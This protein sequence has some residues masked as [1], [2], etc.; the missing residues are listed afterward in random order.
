M[1]TPKAAWGAKSNF[2]LF[3][4]ASNAG[5]LKVLIENFENILERKS[6]KRFQNR[7]W[8]LI[9]MLRHNADI[10]QN[11]D[12]P[13][14]ENTLVELEHIKNALEK[15]LKLFSF[16]EG[17]NSITS[18]LYTYQLISRNLTD[19]R[20]PIAGI[21]VFS[22]QL[23]EITN[24]IKENL[25]KTS[26]NTNEKKGAN[27]SLRNKMR[28]I[29]AEELARLFDLELEMKPTKYRGGK[30]EKCF[31][32]LLE[33]VKF[34]I[35]NRKLSYSIPADLLT[36][37]SEAIDN[38]PNKNSILLSEGEIYAGVTGDFST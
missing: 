8:Q 33:S 5:E 1:P 6:T 30:F 31:R 29:S 15:N 16:N 36:I 22:Q 19:E 26:E 14:M 38:Y 7:V 32:L 12:F 10:Y 35:E 3:P 21:F 2:N 28:D 34:N 23:L 37:I 4:Y 18:K 25:R 24:S 9:A 20:D 11:E 27:K 17:M 13:K